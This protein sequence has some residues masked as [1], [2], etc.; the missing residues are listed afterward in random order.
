MFEREMRAASSTR[1][2]EKGAYVNVTIGRNLTG[3]S[4]RTRKVAKQKGGKFGV[5]WGS[6]EATAVSSIT[7]C[8]K[9]F[10]DETI[11]RN[12]EKIISQ[13]QEREL[14]KK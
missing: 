13:G 10:G 5:R 14:T 11:Q 2:G 9:Y 8:W 6:L 7:R 1:Q 4:P 3:S 12:L